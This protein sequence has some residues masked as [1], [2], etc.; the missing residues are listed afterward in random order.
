MRGRAAPCGGSFR[1]IGFGELQARPHRAAAV[2]VAT[3]S[4]EAQ[5]PTFCPATSL[6]SDVGGRWEGPYALGLGNVGEIT[7]A[8][9]L[10]PRWNG[11]LQNHPFVGH[12]MFIANP[13][14]PLPAG[15]SNTTTFRWNPQVP[16]VL[17]GTHAVPNTL[18]DDLWCGGHAF[19]A[20]GDWIVVGGTDFLSPL[21]NCPNAFFGSRGVYRWDSVAGLWSFVGLLVDPR[22]YPSSPERWN[23]DLLVAGHWQLPAGPEYR[24]ERI[25]ATGP[26]IGGLANNDAWSWNAAT[27][28]CGAP[29]G[30]QLFADGYAWFHQLKSGAIFK[31]GPTLVKTFTEICGA[32]GDAWVDS[33]VPTALDRLDGNAVHLVTLVP[34]TAVHQETIYI[35]GGSSN[36][37]PGVGACNGSELS[38]V[39]K[40]DNPLPFGP[41]WQSVAPMGFPRINMSTVILPDGTFVV[42]GGHGPLGPTSPCNYWLAPEL[43]DPVANTWQAVNCHTHKRGYHGVSFLTLEGKVVSAGSVADTGPLPQGHSVEIWSPGYLFKGLRPSILSAPSG[44][45]YGNPTTFKVTAQVGKLGQTISRV[46]LVRPSSGTHGLDINQR[47]VELRIASTVQVA[48]DRFDVFVNQPEDDRTCPPGWYILFVLAN[49]G[50]PSVGGFLHIG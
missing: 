45:G 41:P 7:H 23:G 10:P 25:F 26:T 5:T 11:T 17:A 20:N 27:Q 13:G 36:P 38:S 44:I 28:S 32:S 12:A 14:C 9:L 50:V 46:T 49:N 34:G 21:T 1:S 18:A 24:H 2:L 16:S 19:L 42:I 48:P 4:T 22:W 30:F 8:G 15:Y 33:G 3:Q 39:E 43:Y 6:P 29:L 35:L 37:A 47:F 40:L 31:S